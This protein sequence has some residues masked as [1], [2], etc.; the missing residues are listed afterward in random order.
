MFY[1]PL[2]SDVDA[3]PEVATIRDRVN[4]SEPSHFVSPIIPIAWL[5]C[6][7]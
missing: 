1:K 3:V 7:L 6:I 2:I 5:I 4:I